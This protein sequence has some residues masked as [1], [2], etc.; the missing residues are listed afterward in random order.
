MSGIRFVGGADWE[1]IHALHMEAFPPEIAPF[2]ADL[3]VALSKKISDPPIY[4]IL[5]EDVGQVL[6]HVVFCPLFGGEV[7]MYNL[8]PLAVKPRWQNA[9]I[10]GLLVRH[11]INILQERR[12]DFALVYGDPAYYSRFGFDAEMGHYFKVP[13]ELTYPFGWQ[14]LGLGRRRPEPVELELPELLMDE[15]LW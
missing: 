5:Y 2:V 15:R 12:V 7:S 1:A 14:A 9:G 11:G 8:T 3:A 6:G 13:Y 10:G 4:S